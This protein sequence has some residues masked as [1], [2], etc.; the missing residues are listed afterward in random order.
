MSDFWWQVAEQEQQKAELLEELEL[1]DVVTCDV[2]RHMSK[3]QTKEAIIPTVSFRRLVCKQK[4]QVATS[5]NFIL[6][7]FFM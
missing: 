5:I 7:I 3:R 1:I 2:D 4:C 6:K